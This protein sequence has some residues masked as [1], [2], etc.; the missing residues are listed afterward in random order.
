[1]DG[2]DAADR[3]AGRLRCRRAAHQGRAR[4]RRHLPH[5]RPEDLHHLWRARPHRQHH[6]LRAGAAARCAGRHQGHLAVPRAEIPGQRGRLAR[7]AQR[8]ARAF[9]RAQARHPRLADLHHGLWRQRR[10]GRL[11]GRRGEPRPRLHVHHDEQRAPRRR[12]A[13]RRR[14]PNARR[15][16]RSPMRATA[17]RAAPSDDVRIE[18]R[19]S[20]IRTSSACC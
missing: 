20:I 12:P 16:R 10:R 15:S 4:G 17:S 9:G 14:S 11:S 13:G 6:P 8:R 7:R 5:H 2:H 1:M 3:A 18:R 19:S